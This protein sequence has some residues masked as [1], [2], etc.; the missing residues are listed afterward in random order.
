M[1]ARFYLHAR[2]VQLHVRLG[3][4]LLFRKRAGTAAGRLSAPLRAPL[5]QRT[6]CAL[7]APLKGG[8][9]PSGRRAVTLGH[10]DSS[11]QAQGTAA[12]RREAPR[13]SLD[14]VQH[15]AAAPARR[16]RPPHGRRSLSLSWSRTHPHSPCVR[17]QRS[18]TGRK[19]PQCPVERS[20]HTHPRTHTPRLR[21]P[22]HRGPAAST[23]TPAPAACTGS[24]Y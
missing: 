13:R 7:S 12:P 22:P 4:V 18:D 5:A 15:A 3:T 2:V 11:P 24:I 9:K 1:R 10:K 8:P 14:V 19:H 17:G 20:P 16:V 6:V 21:R 23:D